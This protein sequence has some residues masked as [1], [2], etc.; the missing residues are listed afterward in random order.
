M[1][2]FVFCAERSG[3]TTFSMVCS[4][5][6]N[7]T[8]AHEMNQCS[9]E[10]HLDFTYPD[11][12]IEI[13]N[14]LAF[15]FGKIYNNY[16]RSPLYILLVRNKEA[17][18][19][20]LVKRFHDR[21]SIVDGYAES[22]IGI[23]PEKLSMD[24]KRDVARLYIESIHENIYLFLEGQPNVLLINLESPELWFDEFW[25]R[26]KAEGDKDAARDELSIKHNPS[27]KRQRYVLLWELK[28]LALRLY[29]KYQRNEK[30]K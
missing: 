5:I 28:L 24:Q 10:R 25:K 26:I 9:L 1:R 19:D 20:S 4:H 17:V 13:D 30:Y 6:T 27:H 3:S 23:R 21:G 7:F 8:T 2:V 12:H 14:R 29:R 22:I 11:N 16:G 15:N 18:I